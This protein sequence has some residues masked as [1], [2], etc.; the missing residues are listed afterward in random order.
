MIYSM[1]E[2]PMW[3]GTCGLH[4]VGPGRLRR[5]VAPTVPL[6]LLLGHCP[7]SRPTREPRRTGTISL[8][9]AAGLRWPGLRPG[10]ERRLR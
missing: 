9:R 10:D 2:L 6:R 1:A 7:I 3:L 8:S 5:S 4:H